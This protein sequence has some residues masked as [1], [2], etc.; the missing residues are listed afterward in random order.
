MGFDFQAKGGNGYQSGGQKPQ[1]QNKQGG[2]QAAGSKPFQ[3]YQRE[4]LPAEFYIPFVVY[5]NDDIPEEVRD[6]LLSFVMYLQKNGLT[7]RVRAMKGIEADI[8]DT[9]KAEV[10]L[11]WNGF[12]ERNSKFTFTPPQARTLAALTWPGYEAA[13]PV[14]QTF[15]AANIR[16][17]LGKDLRQ[18]ASFLL[19]WTSDGCESIESKTQST[20]FAAHPLTVA[21]KVYMPV[22]NFAKPD[23][24]KRICERLGISS[25]YKAGAKTPSNIKEEDI[26]Y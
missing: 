3:R 7:P 22:Y 11:P 18:N 10:H 23:C 8:A 26:P 17:L 5:S 6:N 2:S 4:D 15:M 21:S 24:V 20:G 19:L 25:D 9:E 12:D 16:T 14:V 13:R 1:W